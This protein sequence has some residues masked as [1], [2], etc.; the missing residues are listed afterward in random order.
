MPPSIRAASG[1][2]RLGL[3]DPRDAE[4]R[5]LAVGCRPSLRPVAL[6]LAE[7]SGRAGAVTATGV[8]HPPRGGPAH[9]SFDHPEVA[10]A[11][12]RIGDQT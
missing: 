5:P 6:P 8:N 12:D 7:Q 10:E 3:S 1:P 4:V 2:R 9:D 11:D